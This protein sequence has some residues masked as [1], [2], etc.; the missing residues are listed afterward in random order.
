MKTEPKSKVVQ[1]RLITSTYGIIRCLA[2]GICL[3]WNQNQNS[4][5]EKSLIGFCVGVCDE[6][7]VGFC[8][9]VAL[10]ISA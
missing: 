2:F 10:G 5:N 8:V 7:S 6:L 1:K 4:I 9:G 3:E